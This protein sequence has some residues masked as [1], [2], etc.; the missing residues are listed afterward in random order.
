MKGN[1]NQH[2]FV[3]VFQFNWFSVCF[4]FVYLFFLHF[5]L[6]HPCLSVFRGR[7]S[8]LQRNLLHVVRYFW[9]LQLCIVPT[10]MHSLPQQCSAI[11]FPLT[12]SPFVLV[13]TVYHYLFMSCFINSFD[14]FVI[15]DVVVYCCICISPCRSLPYMPCKNVHA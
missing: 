15:P 12:S 11:L 2:E 14:Q 7:G 8:F 4:Y 3:I 1:M 9:L 10:I 6:Q 5:C 13:H